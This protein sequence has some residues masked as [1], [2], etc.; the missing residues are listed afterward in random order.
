MKRLFLGLIV[1]GG[2]AM[3]AAPAGA[4]PIECGKSYA[5]LMTGADPTMVT[6]DGSASQPGALTHAVGVGTITFAAA[7]GPTATGCAIAQGELIYNAGSIQ[8][9][10]AGLIFGPD[11]CYDGAS[12]LGSGV[13]CFNGG[14]NMTGALT[15]SPFGNGAF[16]LVL[17]ASAAWVDGSIVATTVPFHFTIQNGL[18]G[19]TLAGGGVAAPGAPI[20]QLTMSKM[21]TQ[22]IPTSIG[23]SP[24][25]GESAV[26]C[27]AWGANTTDL[28]A[29]GQASGPPSTY[30][31]GAQSVIGQDVFFPPGPTP[32]G[33]GSLSFNSNDNLV[34]SG[35]PGSNNDCA[36]S[37]FAG[38]QC[39]L[40]NPSCVPPAASQFADG[41]SNTVAKIDSSGLDC[42][43]TSTA[44]AGYSNSAVVWGAANSIANSYVITT[45]LYSDATGF[46]PGPGGESSCTTYYAA[47]AGNVR[48]IKPVA[49]IVNATSPA[50][51][52]VTLTNTSPA[53]CVVHMAMSGTTT[54]GIC[55]LTADPTVDVPG[56]SVSTAGKVHCSCPVEEGAG[57]ATEAESAG[58]SAT[59]TLTSPNCPLSGTTSGSVS[60]NN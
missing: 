51:G 11:H 37:I 30:A 6:A 44:G 22:P 53:D 10:P 52:T 29:A 36:F 14:A 28:V 20:L 4:S 54:D 7:S 46:T 55:T 16:D 39:A 15:V 31:G 45:A 59:L 57:T 32:P 27:L 3:L 42:S 33:G 56:D 13:P 48:N 12:L 34:I 8:T 1:V 2:L 43:T 19:S 21:P 35:T 47:A 26:S 38:T 60:C 18:A 50:D 49:L 5:M 23:A 58:I 17:S 24:Y 40:I 41:A 9:S 25:L